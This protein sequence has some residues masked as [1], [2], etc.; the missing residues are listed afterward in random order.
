[1]D[2][3]PEKDEW[4]SYPTAAYQD[5][6]AKLVHFSAKGVNSNAEAGGVRL[7]PAAGLSLPYVSARCLLAH[8]ATLQTDYT[9]NAGN[10]ATVVKQMRKLQSGEHGETPAE[11][12]K[13]LAVITQAQAS[14][15]QEGTEFVSPRLRQLLLPR[16]NNDY[17]AVSPLPCGGLSKEINSRVQAHT[18]KQARGSGE[19][20]IP[21]RLRVGILGVGGANPQNVG[22]LVREMQTVLVFG[23]PRENQGLRA[24]YRLH[25]S[26]IRIGLP[27]AAMQAWCR[28][29]DKA[30]AG[31][32]GKIPTDMRSREAERDLLQNVTQAVLQSGREAL[33]LLES[34]R[35]Q[36]PNGQLLSAG[37]E[38][39]VIRGLI[40]PTERDKDW[41][42][43]FGVRVAEAI[44]HYS[45]GEKQGG[46]AL[47]SGSLDHIASLVEEVAR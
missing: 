8:G 14:G 41:P 6:A 30:K 36:L 7:A 29:R 33:A 3:K 22:S 23:A 32:D 27:H 25:H 28:W 2:V 42:R 11:A 38:D 18:V 34:Q 4:K 43:Q 19:G 24:A 21:H 16:G 37:F 9:K 13:A 31:N 46:I 20:E 39:A 35:E 10:T 44:S 47:D 1:M 26:G 17:L 15:Y 5:V 12:E 40:D 45:F